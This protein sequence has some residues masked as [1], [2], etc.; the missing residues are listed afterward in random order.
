[1]IR[2]R[3]A[4]PGLTPAMVKDIRSGYAYAHM[5]ELS[6]MPSRSRI[7]QAL[8]TFALSSLS[9]LES[10]AGPVYRALAINAPLIS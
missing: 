10:N 3:V 4:Q 6:V 8:T 5:A 7:K 1:M 2:S 9:S